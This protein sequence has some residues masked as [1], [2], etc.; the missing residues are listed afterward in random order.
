MDFQ[1]LFAVA[2]MGAEAILWVLFALSVVSLAMIVERWLSL[3]QVKNSSR[4]MRGRVQ[5]ILQTNQLEDVEILSQDRSSLEGRALN[6]GIR[7]A[8][9]NG[10]EGLEEIMTTFSLNE[11]PHLERNLSFLATVGSNAPYIGLLGTVLG[12]MKA[13]DDLASS[14]GQ[15]EAVLTGIAHA[16]TATAVG[17]LVAIPAVIAYNAYSRQVKTIMQSIESVKELCLAYAKT[18]GKKNGRANI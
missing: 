3:R 16:L 7:H 17:L 6:Y 8:Q 13:F 14:S 4:N 5:E 2:Q 10:A 15:N 18:I 12:I 1:K 11:R 9:K